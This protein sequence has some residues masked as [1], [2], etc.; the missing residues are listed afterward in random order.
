MPTDLNELR[1]TA[2]AKRAEIRAL[3][4]RISGLAAAEKSGGVATSRGRRNPYSGGLRPKP[5]RGP[6]TALTEATR[7]VFRGASRSA[8]LSE[9]RQDVAT[10]LQQLKDLLKRIAQLRGAIIP[11]PGRGR[12]TPLSAGQPIL[13]AP[14]RLETRFV[15]SATPNEQYDLLVRIYPDQLAL[16]SHNPELNRSELDAARNYRTIISAPDDP[17]DPQRNAAAW[18]E[19]VRKFGEG[20]ARWLARRVNA[21][22]GKRLDDVPE[23]TRTEPAKAR[24]L[25]DYFVMRL[26]RNGEP[27]REERG[28]IIPDELDMPLNPSAT[29]ADEALKAGALWVHDFRA[30]FEAGMAVIFHG[31]SREEA[32]AGYD[33]VV[34]VGV[35]WTNDLRQSKADLEAVL[36]SHLYTRGLSFP[37]YGTPTNNTEDARASAS[38][39]SEDKYVVPGTEP[40][41][42]VATSTALGNAGRLSFALGVSHDLLKSAGGSTDDDQSISSRWMQQALWP[43]IWGYFFRRLLP[44]V[45]T[46][47]QEFWMWDHYRLFVRGQGPLPAI[48]I[49]KLPYGLIPVTRLDNWEASDRDKDALDD[50]ITPAADVSATE[51]RAYRM[52]V[53]LSDLW[54]SFALN[55]ALVPRIGSTDDPDQ[56]L[57]RI[58]AMEPRSISA[59]RRTIFDENLLALLFNNLAGRFFGG[60]TWLNVAGRDERYWRERWIEAWNQSR[61]TALQL[62]SHLASVIGASAAG[63]EDAPLFHVFSWGDGS[64]LSEN[65]ASDTTADAEELA[66]DLRSQAENKDGAERAGLLFELL[67]RSLRLE[68]LFL[69]LP[70]VKSRVKEAVLALAKRKLSQQ[71]LDGLIRDALDLSSHRFDAWLTS[72]ATKRAIAMRKADGAAN[73]CHL[74]AYGWVEGLRLETKA[75][76]GFIHAPSLDQAKAAAIVRSAY[77]THIGEDGGNIA[78]TDLSS[79]RVRMALELMRGIGP[80]Q[81][82]GALLGYQF[83]RDLHDRTLDAYIDTFRS[84]YPLVANSVTPAEPDTPTEAIAARNV[85]DGCA[86]AT[87]WRTT[88]NLGSISSALGSAP[89]GLAEALDALLDSLD[90]LSDLGLYESI[91]QSIKGRFE[92]AGAALDAIAGIGRAPEFESVKTPVEEIRYGNRFCV[93]LQGAPAVDDKLAPRVSAEPTLNAWVAGIIGG[94]DQIKCRAIFPVPDNNQGWDEMEVTVSDLGLGPLDFMYASLPHPKGEDT[95]IELRIRSLV[96]REKR[97]PVDS[98]PSIDFG[99]LQGGGRS[100]GEAMELARRLLAVAGNASYLKPRNLTSVAQ[101][102]TPPEM[103]ASASDAPAVD[104]SGF[105]EDDCTKLNERASDA[106]SRLDDIRGAL[107]NPGGFFQ[108]PLADALRAASLHGIEGLIPKIAD[109][110]DELERLR[111]IALALEKIRKRLDEYDKRI[112]EY[113]QLPAKQYG[114]RIDKLI[115]AMRELLGKSFIVLPAFTPPDVQ[116]EELDN[117]RGQVGIVGAGGDERVM[118]WFQ[119]MAQV[120][121][122]VQRVETLMMLSEAWR[123]DAATSV[124]ECIAAPEETDIPGAGRLQVLQLPFGANAMLRKKVDGAWTEEPVEA[125][126]MA[127]SDEEWRAIYG[128]RVDDADRLERPRGLVSVVSLIPD[129]GMEFNKPIAGLLIDGWDEQIPGSSIETGVAFH[130]NQPS[131]QAP[132]ALLLAVPGQHADAD[133]KWS[134]DEV[135]QIVRDTMKLAKIR[136]VDPDALQSVGRFLPAVFLPAD[137]TMPALDFVGKRKLN[138]SSQPV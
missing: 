103:T 11:P 19:L 15:R 34:A 12:P 127:L 121:A 116:A 27:V 74:G 112:N 66:S 3:R 45:L 2:Q 105:S 40:S 129:A 106:R 46:Q 31:I 61:E 114:K 90:A 96:R 50:P 57:I 93:L 119:Q 101:G 62:L 58:L 133:S 70:S 91:F 82:L 79:R 86:L 36:A 43:A 59:Q 107:E 117:A 136:M 99:R 30:A 102:E 98:K 130:Y 1:Q 23:N 94:L 21:Y 72:F 41:S 88:R 4:L 44:G 16:D 122:G 137:S 68:G 22:D 87:A 9:F 126:W 26:Y 115:E 10:K 75:S 20:R 67:W 124:A 48:R 24:L 47:L 32:E 111:A 81:P 110:G 5:R 64:P 131:S 109:D 49:G 84:L 33:E 53:D 89:A 37:P 120:R 83:E 54:L 56:E 6:V 63:L 29:S 118:Q 77:L 25:P 78:R 104:T 13:L 71:E 92:H 134:E 18:R 17:E 14:V 39:A 125:N 76:D 42:A 80:G 138:P 132:Q 73:G 38:E 28:R 55:P 95:E 108:P 123:S 65:L 128:E 97:L 135:V 35:K 113:K 85:V 60:N 52:L 8:K 100:M 51:S 7:S 69:K